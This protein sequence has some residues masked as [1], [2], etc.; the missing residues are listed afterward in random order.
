MAG[1]EPCLPAGRQLSPETPVL[2][3]GTTHH[4][5]RISIDARL[6]GI[7]VEADRFEL[8]LTVFHTT[9]LPLELYF[10]KGHL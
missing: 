9:A 2:Q 4:H 5:C 1:F 3:T 10:H 8:S 7:L 6:S